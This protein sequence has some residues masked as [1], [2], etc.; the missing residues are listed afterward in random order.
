MS[1][2]ENDKVYNAALEQLHRRECRRSLLSF[3]KYTHPRWSSGRHHIKM[4]HYLELLAR[5][6]NCPDCGHPITKLNI[7]APPR[8]TKT[9]LCSRRFPAWYLGQDP[10]RQILNAQATGQLAM[11]T[12]ADVRNIVREPEY[13]RIFPNVELMPDAQA[14]GRWVTKEGGIYYAAGVDGTTVGRGAHLLVMDDLVKG[15]EAADSVRMRDIAGNWYFANAIT[16]L[17]PDAIQLLIATRWH[18]DDPTGRILTPQDMWRPTNDPQFFCAGDWHVLRLR[19]IENVGT[20]REQALWPEWYN[21]DYLQ[22]LR[23]TMVEGGRGREWQAQYQQEPVAEE[24]TYLKRKWFEDRYEEAPP[25][26]AYIVTDFAVTKQAQRKDPDRTEIGVVGYH[27]DGRVYVL[28]WST[29]IDTPD[30]WIR[31]LLRLIKQYRPY[32]V[33]GEKGIIRNAVEPSIQEAMRKEK[34]YARFVW[35]STQGDKMARGRPLQAMAS[36][37]RIVFPRY[38]P[39]AENMIDELVAVG[40]GGRYDDKFDAL[41]HFCLAIDRNSP[42]VSKGINRRSHAKK[43]P[44]QP[45]RVGTR[46]RWKTA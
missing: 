35:M 2:R 16:R 36:C 42:A 11:D 26:R 38:S 28:D 27:S 13:R 18:E 15:R 14:A 37:G 6:A 4:C 21:L 45:V 12:G 10:T 5:K 7:N 9:E 24:G 17:M 32:G 46:D 41:A 20:T 22:S 19:A 25:A 3:S 34:T 1:S 30:V 40:G 23:K 8:H 29:I 39:W 43:D 31:E 33:F 44:W